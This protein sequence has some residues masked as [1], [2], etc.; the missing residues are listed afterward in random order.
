MAALHF[1]EH[2]FSLPDAYAKAV[3]H[4]LELFEMGGERF[5][6]LWTGG[7]GE[8]KPVV[9]RLTKKQARDLATGA[10]ALFSRI[11]D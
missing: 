10:D 6:R 8:N 1:L 4:D 3:H 9:C 7:L 5:L 2:E 11:G